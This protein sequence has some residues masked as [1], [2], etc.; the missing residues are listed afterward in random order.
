VRFQDFVLA[1]NTRKT[2]HYW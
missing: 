2:N 1:V